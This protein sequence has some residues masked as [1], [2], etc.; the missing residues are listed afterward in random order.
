MRALRQNHRMPAIPEWIRAERLTLRRWTDADR[1]PFAALNADPEVMEFFPSTLDRAASDAFVDRIEATFEAKG[2]GLWVVEVDRAG[3]FAGFVGLYPATFEAPF[4]PSVEIGWRLAKDH[5]GNG[6]ATE[7][8]DAALDDGFERLRLDEI[9]S[10]S[11]R[12]MQRIGMHRDP[13]DDFDHPQVRPG[14]RLRP[15]VLYRVRS[16]DR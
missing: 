7:A 12:V 6:Y 1:A 4:N 11:Q 14:D 2:F 5:W 9:V 3:A 8:A 16:E 13:A 10:R 15:H